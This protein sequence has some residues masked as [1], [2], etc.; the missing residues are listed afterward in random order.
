MVS[1]VCGH[2]YEHDGWSKDELCPDCYFEK[3]DTDEEWYAGEAAIERQSQERAWFQ[4][5]LTR[6]AG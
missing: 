6:D 2:E 5:L 1:P 3:W 4:S